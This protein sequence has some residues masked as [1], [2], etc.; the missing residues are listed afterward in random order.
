MIETIK[1]DTFLLDLQ[2]SE[3]IKRTTEYYGWVLESSPGE[4]IWPTKKVVSSAEALIEQYELTREEADFL[5]ELSTVTIEIPNENLL[6]FYPS[7]SES[8]DAVI[9]GIY[10][11]GKF[12]FPLHFRAEVQNKKMFFP[13]RPT[14]YK[15]KA[16]LLTEAIKKIQN[17]EIEI[18][19]VRLTPSHPYGWCEVCLA[20]TR[21][22]NLFLVILPGK[23]N[24]QEVDWY[25][26]K[27]DDVFRFIELL[28]K[29][30]FQPT[31][32]QTWKG[33]A[34]VLI[35]S[36]GKSLSVYG[37]DRTGY[38]GEILY[39]LRFRSLIRQ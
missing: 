16:E 13:F 10:I 30:G 18:L 12:S 3:L 38:E 34:G 25:E 33:K 6:R 15:K 35:G 32:Q 28:E 27:I 22:E 4:A 1:R 29:E 8:C 14:E 5:C 19:E 23:V 17:E 11:I 21:Q 9:N 20:V 31:H 36:R 37:R 2:K 26:F 7:E 39:S 24:M